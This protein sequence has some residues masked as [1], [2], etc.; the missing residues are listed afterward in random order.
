MLYAR[1][2][3]EY[4]SSSPHIISRLPISES[5]CGG[6]SFLINQI[7]KVI[8]ESC[9]NIIL[10]YPEILRV[11]TSYPENISKHFSPL[12]ISDVVRIYIEI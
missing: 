6:E 10:A 8:Y 4:Q 12:K 7:T 11:F 1:F 3:Q 9:P 2:F 5:R